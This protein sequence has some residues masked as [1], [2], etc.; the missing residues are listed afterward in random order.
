MKIFKWV[1]VGLGLIFAFYLLQGILAGFKSSF[2][3]NQMIDKAK[4]QAAGYDV[5]TFNFINNERA[6]I[7]VQ[8]LNVSEKLCAYAKKKSKELSLSLDE[9]PQIDL[10]KEVANPDNNIYFDEFTSI[11]IN[12]Q[13][14]GVAK[15][16]SSNLSNLFVYQGSKAAANPNF[17]NGCVADSAESNAGRIYTVFVAGQTK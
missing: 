2:A 17:T 6:K 9:Q 10:T 13:G 3:P 7:G 1:L 5:E 12:Y 11:G 15:R 4:N 14:G 16:P 8:K